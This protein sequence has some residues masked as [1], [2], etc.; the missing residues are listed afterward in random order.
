MK[1]ATK[2]KIKFLTSKTVKIELLEKKID[3]IKDELESW[4]EKNE[5][6][7]SDYLQDLAARSVKDKYHECPRYMARLMMVDG[8]PYH[9][10]QKI[11]GLTPRNLYGIR[12]Y[13][14][15]LNEAKK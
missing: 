2:N 7:I 3:N 5:K 13:L 12:S 8:L 6:E 4:L 1:E 14:K 10:I 11:T 9:Y 15:K